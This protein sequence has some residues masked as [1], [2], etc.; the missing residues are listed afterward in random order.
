MSNASTPICVG[1]QRT[2]P[3]YLMNQRNVKAEFTVW[4]PSL[5]MCGNAS[6]CCTLTPPNGAL[7][8]NVNLN[9]IGGSFLCASGTCE[10]DKLQ[11]QCVAT[12][13]RRDIGIGM[14][15]G[16]ITFLILTLAAGIAIVYYVRG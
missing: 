12:T 6:V 13:V 10:S 5:N 15:I 2:K 7:V 4:Q 11:S 9:L 14:S 8:S 3:L 16:S 1:Y